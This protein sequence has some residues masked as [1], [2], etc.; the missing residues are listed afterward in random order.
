MKLQ[1]FEA[2]PILNFGCVDISTDKRKTKSIVLENPSKT[3]MVVSIQRGPASDTFSH[4]FPAKSIAI[5]AGAQEAINISWKPR[6]V[7][8]MRDSIEFRTSNQI[9]ARLILLGTGS[10]IGFSTVKVC[11]TA[12]C[13]TPPI[14]SLLV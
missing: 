5:A 9:H 7:G 4:T 6:E 10:Q 8:N 2:A 12:P 13:F 1:P 14:I 3:N 11:F